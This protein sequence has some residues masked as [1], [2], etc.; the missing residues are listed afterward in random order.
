MNVINPLKYFAVKNK[1]LKKHSFRCYEMFYD[2]A[3]NLN[4]S[5]STIISIQ[6]KQLLRLYG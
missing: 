3:E 1:C 4:E 2:E 5:F 6:N